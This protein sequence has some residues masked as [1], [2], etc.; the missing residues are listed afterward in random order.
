MFVHS[1][2][3]PADIIF[4]RELEAIAAVMPNLR[5]VHICE[6]DYPSE[7]WVGM[8]GRLSPACST[9]DCPDLPER[10]TYT[11]GPPAYMDAV[12]RILGEPGYDMANYHEESFSFESLPLAEQRRRRS[13]GRRLRRHRRRRRRPAD[14]GVATYTVEFVRSGRTVTCRADENVLDAALAAGVRLPSSCSQGMCGT[15]KTTMLSGEVEM[16][17]QRRHPAQRGR[18]EKILICCSKPLSDL[19]LEA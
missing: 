3:T 2:R 6:S 9:G 7:R 19:W 15:C 8:R 17:P 5:V 16:Q 4:R 12:R 13:R 14:A 11:C 1:A 18:A 10:V